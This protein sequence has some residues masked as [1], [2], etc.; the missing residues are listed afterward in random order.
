MLKIH[1]GRRPLW[2]QG[3]VVS[4]PKRHHVMMTDLHKDVR[5]LVEPL[6]S[7]CE[8]CWTSKPSE[9]PDMTKI[10]GELDM[11]LREK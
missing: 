8:L 4:T 7:L 11:I 10:E 9:R 1:G 2:P 6:K 5:T 3:G